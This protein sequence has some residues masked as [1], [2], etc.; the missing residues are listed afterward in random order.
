MQESNYHQYRGNLNSRLPALP[1]P[2][3]PAPATEIVVDGAPPAARRDYL[4]LVRKYIVLGVV[5]V[6]VCGIAGFVSV[7]LFAPMYKAKAVIEIQSGNDSFLKMGQNG[8]TEEAIQINIQ[9]QIQLLKSLSFLRKVVGRLQLETVPPAP[10]QSDIFAKMRNRLKTVSQDPMAVM[11][12]G[13]ETAAATLQARSITGTRII[14]VTCESTNPEIASDFVNAVANEYAEQ[15]LQGRMQTAQEGSRWLQGELEETKTRLQDAQQRLQDFVRTSGNLFVLQDNTLADTKLRELQAQVANIQA[16]RIAK[17]SK[18]EQVERT[19]AASLPDVLDDPALRNY[20]GRIGDL[21]QQMAAMLT[22]LQP[23]NPKVEKVQAQISELEATLNKEIAGARERA[24]T[25]YQAALRREKLLR[26]AY[27]AQAGQ[28]SS[29]AS[30]ATQYGALR[31]EVDSLQQTYNTMSLQANESTIASQLP[32]NQVKVVDPSAP[33]TEPYSPKPF[34]NISLGVI[35]GLMLTAGIAFLWEKKDDSVRLPGHARS[36]LNVPELGVIP[37]V[38]VEGAKKWRFGNRNKNGSEEPNRDFVQVFRSAQN[39]QTAF[40]PAESFRVTLASLL[41]ESVTGGRPQAILVTSPSP[42]EGKTT[43]VSNLGM[44]LAET[45]RSVLLVDGDFRRPRLHHVFELPNNWGLTSLLVEGANMQDGVGLSTAFPGLSV[46]P[47]G[48]APENIS[49][50]L[51]SPALRQFFNLVRTRFDFILIDAPPIL[52]VAD[53]RVM[54]EFADGAVLVLRAGSTDRSDA[55]QAC[56]HLQEDGTVLLG[57]VLNDW[58][59]TRKT[60]NYYEY[61]AGRREE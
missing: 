53:A 48:P 38:R 54:G 39:G 14:E 6:L 55:L 59:P 29:E 17:Q 42:A 16:D 3:L 1:A 35:F 49:K 27:D 43:V 5:L 37:T 36:L 13:L 21:K 45:G 31:R 8:G 20:Q 51:Y 40:R 33:A 24:S 4:Q 11:K 60:K 52:E 22:T 23:G 30:K 15:S 50:V 47:S 19:P 18:F 2:Y 44:A 10:V 46:L 56:Q 25:D 32:I 58:K 7:A 12:D 34:V 26:A 28:V 9:T 41:R 61:Y 57:T